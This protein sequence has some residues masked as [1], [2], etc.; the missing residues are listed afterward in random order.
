MGWILRHFGDKPSFQQ[1]H[2]IILNATT[3]SRLQQILETLWQQM[4]ALRLRSVFL[5]SVMQ[6]G[7]TYHQQV[8]AAIAARDPVLAEQRMR[9]HVHNVRQALLS[10]VEGREIRSFSDYETLLSRFE[11]ATVPARTAG[12]PR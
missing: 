5:P 3:S 7:V 10:M 1:F 8:F 9:D 2:R 11:V 12:A 4:L 6:D